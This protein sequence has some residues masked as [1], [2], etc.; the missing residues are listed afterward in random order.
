ML[1]IT[2]STL[3]G[4][5]AKLG[6]GGLFN[7]GTAK[8]TD[9]TIADNFANQ[10][11]SLLA[12]NGGGVDNSG[13]ATLLACTVTG[14]TTTADGGGLYNGGLGSDIMSLEDTIVAGNSTTSTKS[15]VYGDIGV[16]TIV[17]TTYYV[18]GTYDLVGTGGA[19][20]LGAGT[21]RSGSQT[22]AWPRWATTAGRRRPSR[23]SPAARPL[24]RARRSPA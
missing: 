11:G 4:N 10:A 22:R 9:S 18:T 6:G 3:S 17:N 15:S 12:S 8:V 19:G 24:G 2:G 5:T 13:T 14:N 1:T 7:N 23:C 21:T 20:G 16:E